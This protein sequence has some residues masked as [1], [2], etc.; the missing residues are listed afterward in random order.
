MPGISTS[1]PFGMK[2][3]YANI[4]HHAKAKGHA[5]NFEDDDEWLSTPNQCMP[6]SSTSAPVRMKVYTNIKKHDAIKLKTTNDWAGD[7]IKNE[8]KLNSDELDGIFLS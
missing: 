5:I 4:K 2:M 6:S 3:K 8:W 7:L 1:A